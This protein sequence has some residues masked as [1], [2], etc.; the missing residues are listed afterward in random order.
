MK[1]G[2]IRCGRYAR[3]SGAGCFTGINQKSG[4]MADYDSIEVVGYSTC[5]GCP[6]ENM[7]TVPKALKKAGAEVIHLT[8]CF[9]CG[10]PPCIHVRDF[11][12]LIGTETGLPVKVG[13][14][15]FPKHYFELHQKLGD[16][17]EK[18]LL[19]LAEPL[20]PPDPAS[21]SSLKQTV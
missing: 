2:I 4:P 9:L 20:F 1:I 13:T 12:R 10:V 3:C 15:R 11:I 14:H 16:W 7:E 18:N 19:D 8:T 17:R 21:P 5:G 6:G